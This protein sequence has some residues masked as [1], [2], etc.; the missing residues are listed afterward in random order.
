MPTCHYIDSGGD[1]RTYGPSREDSSCHEQANDIEVKESDD[2]FDIDWDI[3][4]LQ[5]EKG[6][7][8]CAM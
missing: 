3:S 1:K 4:A 6:S 8:I 2:I 5:V 7:P